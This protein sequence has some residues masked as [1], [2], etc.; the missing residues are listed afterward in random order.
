MTA[1]VEFFCSPDEEREVL[2]YLVN[3]DAMEIFDVHDDQLTPWKPFSIDDLP[4]WPDP[5]HIYVWKPTHGSLIWHTSRPEI[6][7][8]TH[9]SFVINFFAHEKWN[10]LGLSGNDKMLDTDRSPILCYQRGTVHE[11]KQGPNLVLAPPSNLGR[12]GA[13]YERWV[14]RS[15]A[16]IRRRGKIIHDWRQQSETIPNPDM[17]L[18]TIYAFPDVREDLASEN[19]NFA[20]FVQSRT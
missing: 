1:Q 10:E 2:S 11:G 6:A 13:D 5:L 19:H 3:A 20:L 14:K 18:S 16:W 4:D 8:P 7:G 17:L 12:A 9:R 15:L